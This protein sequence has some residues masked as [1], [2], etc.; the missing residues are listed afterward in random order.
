M[1]TKLPQIACVLALFLIPNVLLAQDLRNIPCDEVRPTYRQMQLAVSRQANACARGMPIDAAWTMVRGPSGD[2]RYGMCTWWGPK[3]CA[4]I[5]SRCFAIA[6]GEQAALAHCKRQEER[7]KLERDRSDHDQRRVEEAAAPPGRAR[8]SYTGSLASSD[9]VRRVLTSEDVGKSWLFRSSGRLFLSS[10]SPL[11][12]VQNSPMLLSVGES[13]RKLRM[14]QGAQNL[15]ALAMGWAHAIS[16]SAS[17]AERFQTA[18]SFFKLA[19]RGAMKSSGNPAADVFGRYS[20]TLLGA[21]QSALLSDLNDLSKG[22]DLLNVEQTL[23][24]THQDVYFSVAQSR[25]ELTLAAMTSRASDQAIDTSTSD[26]VSELRAY[27][28][29]IANATAQ[30]ERRTREAQQEAVRPARRAQQDREER[31][32]AFNSFVGGLTGAIVNQPRSAPPPRASAPPPPPS[33][34]T[35]GGGNDCSYRGP[36]SA[37][38]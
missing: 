25:W 14:A 26:L 24:R 19:N 11:S 9:E 20:F 33:R 10:N 4:G 8:P 16:G 12:T 29:Q 34:P 30:R 7:A 15:G 13:L 1:P 35:Y 2:N 32:R 27:A 28:A 22:I 6:D 23:L 21:F 3:A 31:L 38:R 36:G 18:L 5:M 37:C 17:D